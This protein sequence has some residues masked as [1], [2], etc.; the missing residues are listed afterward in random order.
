MNEIIQRIMDSVNKKGV[1]S[2]CKKILKNAVS[3]QIL[4]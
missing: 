2:D 4:I 3:N 1:Q